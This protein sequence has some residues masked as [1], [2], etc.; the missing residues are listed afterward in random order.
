MKHTNIANHSRIKL[1]VSRKIQEDYDLR[2]AIASDIGVRES[3]VYLW[4]YRKSKMIENYFFIQSFKKH[5]QWSDADI[6]EDIQSI[7]DAI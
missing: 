4:A 6:F 2:C 5:T 3:T 1:T 7:I